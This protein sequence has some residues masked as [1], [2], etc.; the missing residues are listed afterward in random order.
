V[1]RT[2]GARACIVIWERDD[3][4]KLPLSAFF[5]EGED[6]AVFAVEDGVARIRTVERGRHT[7]LETQIR[8]GLT[9]GGRV[10]RYPSDAVADG[11][12]VTER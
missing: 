10:V 11:S 4:L 9:P 2:G 7:G 5:R 8:E 12:R 1:G 6:W 3:V